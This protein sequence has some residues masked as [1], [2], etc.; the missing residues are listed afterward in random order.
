MRTIWSTKRVTWTDYFDLDQRYTTSQ[1]IEITCQ[2]PS[3]TDFN[4]QPF[5][6]LLLRIAGNAQGTVS[7]ERLG[8][9]LRKISGRVLNKR[10]LGMGRLNKASA[11]FWLSEA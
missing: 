9:W 3:P 7:P 1:I 8:K 11:C 10:R 5:K 4:R 2:L 6:E